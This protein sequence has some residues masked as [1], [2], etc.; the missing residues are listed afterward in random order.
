MSS[1]NCNN[2]VDTNY[3]KLKIIILPTAPEAF[4]FIMYYIEK[5]PLANS[6]PLLL[7]THYNVL[8][9]LLYGIEW[10]I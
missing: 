5:K 9:T 7:S 3:H 2:S 1:T 10:I 6:Q 4:V 8:A